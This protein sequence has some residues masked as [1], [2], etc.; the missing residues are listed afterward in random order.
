[1]VNITL[2]EIIKED[3]GVMSPTPGVV[4]RRAGGSTSIREGDLV[5]IKGDRTGE[6]YRIVKLCGPMALLI[7]PKI[8]NVD[9]LI[10]VEE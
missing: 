5:K 7:N 3:D 8:E 4:E 2:D 6:K 9:Q 1:M 10:M